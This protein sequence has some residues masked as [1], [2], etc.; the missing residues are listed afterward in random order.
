MRRC[1]PK[2]SIPLDGKVPSED[3]T[4]ILKWALSLV[5]RRRIGWRINT[6]AI[7]MAVWRCESL[8]RPLHPELGR[9][10]PKSFF[11]STMAR[12]SLV[13]TTANSP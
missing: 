11:H 12:V 4:L 2:V 3:I 8:A 13:E 5:V 9:V 10:Y 1:A 7:S 6:R